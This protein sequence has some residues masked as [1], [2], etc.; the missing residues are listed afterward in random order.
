ME[1]A[2]GSRGGRRLLRSIT[3]VLENLDVGTSAIISLVG[4]GL[5][6]VLWTS[7]AAPNPPELALT[8]MSL[9]RRFSVLGSEEGISLFRRA[10][11]KRMALDHPLT[12]AR[13]LGAK[14][15]PVRFTLGTLSLGL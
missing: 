13:R 10:N 8:R 11:G 9:R 15:I 7:G 5:D 3:G 12:L 6:R 1:L 2:C 4:V 14:N